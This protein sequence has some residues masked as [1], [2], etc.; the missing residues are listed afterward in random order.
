M[1]PRVHH[2]PERRNGRVDNASQP[3]QVPEKRHKAILQGRKP[4]LR[5]E[6]LME[7]L[8]IRLA[9]ATPQVDA[10]MSLSLFALLF[11]FAIQGNSA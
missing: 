6:G 10:K 11:Q 2:Q 9:S 4:C 8:T 5:P 7:N 3:S 1:R